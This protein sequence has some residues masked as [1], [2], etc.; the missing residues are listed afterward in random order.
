M[1]GYKRR[2]NNKYKEK[3]RIKD[4]RWL[5]KAI[6]TSII[7][8]VLSVFLSPYLSQFREKASELLFPPLEYEIEEV[9]LLNESDYREQEFEMNYVIGD[10]PINV[11]TAYLE[12]KLNF[13]TNNLGNPNYLYV[14]PPMS[15][16]DESIKADRMQ[17]YSLNIKRQVFKVNI[18]L[19][20]YVDEKYCDI[21]LA[22]KDKDTGKYLVSLVL[23]NSEELPVYTQFMSEQSET[24][25]MYDFTIQA[26][27]PN[28][29]KRDLSVLKLTEEQLDSLDLSSEENRDIY[30][31]KNEYRDKLKKIKED[32]RHD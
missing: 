29:N 18:E 21:Y 14:F 11:H 30:V 1:K 16:N 20:Q 27:N 4:E 12:M 6:T 3:H 22:F 9:K 19:Q 28:I 2:I 31:N 8:I 23:L 17:R 13:D 25:N 15:K 26:I 7:G 5:R 24:S 32:L 10:Q